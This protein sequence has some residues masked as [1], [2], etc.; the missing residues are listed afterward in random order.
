MVKTMLQE[1]VGLA[2][3]GLALAIAGAGCLPSFDAGSTDGGGN[4]LP[5]L[6]SG[7]SD[8]TIVDEGGSMQGTGDGST[9]DGGGG[10][11]PTGDGSSFDATTAVDSGPTLECDAGLSA[12]GASCIDLQSNDDYNCGKCGHSCGAGNCGS[13]VCGTWVVAQPQ[14]PEA[15]ATDGV[16]V[17]WIDPST[18]G[19]G[20]FE[21]ET[22]GATANLL[23]A[24]PNLTTFAGP[25]IQQGVVVWG[26]S[27]GTVWKATAGQMNS[28][29]KQSFTFPGGST[30][31]DALLNGAATH[32]AVVAQS[33]AMVDELYDCTLGTA[34]CADIGPISGGLEA[35]TVNGPT[36]FFSNGTD[37]HAFDFGTT[38]IRTI[39]TGQGRLKDDLVIGADTN[40]VYWNVGGYEANNAITSSGLDG[41][42]LTQVV[43]GIDGVVD[44]LASDGTNLYFTSLSVLT[45]P[46]GGG[47]Q[48]AGPGIVSTAPAA[49]CCTYANLEAQGLAGNIAVGG[50]AIFWIDSEGSGNFIYGL[51]TP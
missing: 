40:R 50:G 41:G 25:S 35:S 10:T 24:D 6:D 2:A 48:L 36:Y 9:A 34:T 7:V 51:K 20:V 47:F 15:L 1:R 49:G 45:L 22:N 26:D 12:C 8:G 5:S 43:T 13:G 46:D 33:S 37:V 17:V 23:Q 16:T 28:G 39:A 21:A 38:T 11:G 31:I 32:V 18:S 3:G 44:S 19:G 29:T 27:T 4:P 14:A 30:L 42:V